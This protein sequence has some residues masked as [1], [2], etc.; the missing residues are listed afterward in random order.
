MTWY[1]L[2]GPKL[3]R[4]IP[5]CL[6]G[7]GGLFRSYCLNCSIFRLLWLTNRHV[8]H[9]V[10]CLL[11]WTQLLVLV[12]DDIAAHHIRSIQAWLV[13]RSCRADSFGVILIGIQV[14]A[15]WITLEDLRR[16]RVNLFDFKIISFSVPRHRHR[17][18]REGDVFRSRLVEHISRVLNQGI[19]GYRY[20]C[21]II[22]QSIC[23]KLGFVDEP[24][25]LGWQLWW[26]NRVSIFNTS[27]IV[28]STA[29]PSPRVFKWRIVSLWSGELRLRLDFT[30]VGATL[31]HQY[32]TNLV[33]LWPEHVRLLTMKDTAGR[34]EIPARAGLRDR[35][36]D[37]TITLILEVVVLDEDG[38]SCRVRHLSYDFILDLYRLGRDRTV[39]ICQAT[40]LLHRP[41]IAVHVVHRVR[42][43]GCV[44]LIGAILGGV[45][46]DVWLNERGDAT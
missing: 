32:P 17:E 5:V 2:P 33:V 19:F 7:C 36:R 26:I 14:F 46:V 9:S 37:Q 24:S 41:G 45:E 29:K 22:L 35:G 30:N 25:W 27:L 12:F 20:A 8:E 42:N 18:M 1:E 43:E 40:L 4:T 28:V 39:Q 15:G 10:H 6:Q 44:A 11:H 21:Q 13:L 3:T 38:G 31:S 34:D 16:A 23:F